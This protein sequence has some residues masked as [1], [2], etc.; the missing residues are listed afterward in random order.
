MS[1]KTK[2]GCWRIFI[3]IG[4]ILIIAGIWIGREYTFTPPPPPIVTNEASDIIRH[5]QKDTAWG[6][7]ISHHQ[8]SVDWSKMVGD[9]RPDFVFLKTTEGTHFTDNRFEDYRSHLQQLRIPFAGYH[10]MRFNKNGKDQ[11]NYFLRKAQPKKGQLI[12][13]VDIEYQRHLYTD[14][15]AQ[16]NIDLFMETIRS[17]IGVYPIVYCE[18]KYYHKYLKKKYKGKIILWI[19]NYKRS[20]TTAWDIWQKTDKFKHPSFKRRIDYNILQHQ[21]IGMKDLILQ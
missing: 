8:G 12:P 14:E 4:I 7:D 19:A 1:K 16:K 17:A 6:I 3:A 21:R 20:P 15:I 10:F 18:E 5:P 2:K 9:K 11:A 13:V